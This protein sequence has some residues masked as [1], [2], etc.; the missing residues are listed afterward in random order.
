M[1]M[2]IWNNMSALIDWLTPF[3]CHLYYIITG[4]VAIFHHSPNI[5]ESTSSSN[6]KSRQKNINLLHKNSFDT[7]NPSCHFVF[8]RKTTPTKLRRAHYLTKVH[9]KQ[10]RV[11]HA[12]STTSLLWVDWDLSRQTAIRPASRCTGK[13]EIVDSW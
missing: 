8:Y 9:L 1:Y 2:E 12:H 3:P 13:G 11:K 5:N 7:T 6:K 4:I 10:I